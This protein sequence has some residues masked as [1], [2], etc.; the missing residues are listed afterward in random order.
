MYEFQSLR[1]QD[2]HRFKNVKKSTKET[3][4]ITLGFHR[5]ACTAPRPN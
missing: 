3:K 2:K 4:E 1:L 5:I